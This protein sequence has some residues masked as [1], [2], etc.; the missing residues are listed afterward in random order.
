MK[1][2]D[3]YSSASELPQLETP[4]SVTASEA[5]AYGFDLSWTAVSDATDYTYYVVRPD[6]RTVATG[7]SWEP[8]VHIGGLDGKSVAGHPYFNVRIVA[9]HM[10]YD[11]GKQEIPQ[12]CRSSE[13]SR[14]L[15]VRLAESTATVYFQD[16]FSWIDPASGSALLA[17][18]TD[19]INTYCTTDTMIRFDKL[20]EEGTSLQGWSY[21]SSKKSVYTRPGYIHL[22]SSSAQGLLISPALTAISGTDDVEVSFDATYFYQYFSKTADTNKTLTIALRG[23]GTIEG[24]TDGVLTVTLSRGNAWESFTFRILRNKLFTHITI[25]IR[26]TAQIFFKRD[27]NI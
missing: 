9:N 7:K 21:D 1:L 23:A 19:W 18:N 15:Q 20:E 12:T 4:G 16:D 17:T 5:S 2:D 24:A 10:N 8:H 6:G 22:N 26:Y 13:S 11:S 14:A 25:R 27:L 3:A